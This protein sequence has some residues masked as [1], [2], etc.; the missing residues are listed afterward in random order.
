MPHR[1]HCDNA[2][3]A[4]IVFSRFNI[5][6]LLKTAH[7]QDSPP[8]RIGGTITVEGPLAHPDQLRG[9]ARLDSLLNRCRRPPGEP[10]G[11]HAM[12]ADARLKLDPLHVTGEETDL[13]VQGSLA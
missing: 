7:I 1:A 11:V 12:L 5:G 9:E 6:G 3:Q 2:T 13:H 4:E 8:I 10:G